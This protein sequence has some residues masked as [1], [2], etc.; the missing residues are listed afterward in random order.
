MSRSPTPP[1][2]ASQAPASFPLIASS[3]TCRPAGT[4]VGSAS[5]TRHPRQTPTRQPASSG[6]R[7][8]VGRPTPPPPADPPPVANPTPPSKQEPR[9]TSIGFMGSPM[10]VHLAKAGHDVVGYNRSPEKTKPL[11]DAGGRAAA[12]VAEAVSGA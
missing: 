11:V 9:M 1:D 2:A 12:S 5:S 4:R 3:P 8:H 7:G 10:A 6:C